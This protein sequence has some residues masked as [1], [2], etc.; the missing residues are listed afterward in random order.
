M[1][2]NRFAFFIQDL[3]GGGAERAV[4]RLANGIAARNIPTDLVLVARRGPFLAEVGAAVEIVELPQSRTVTSVLG[5]ADYVAKRR[6]AALVSHMT[7]TNVAAIAATALTRQRPRL[8]VVEHNRFDVAQ[9]RRRGLPRLAY[10]L[11]PLVYRYADVVAVVADGMRGRIAEAARIPLEKV[12]VLRNPVISPELLAQAKEEPP[13]PWFKPGEVPVILAVGRLTR[14]KNF[15]M[16]LE[17][18]AKL[19]GR[20]AA[21]LVILGEGEERV[22]LEGLIAERRLQADVDLPGFAS[23][24]FAYMA[25]AGVFALSSDWE[26]LPTVLIE[27]LACGVPLVATDCES[28]PA[29]ILDGGRYGRLVATGDANAFADALEA[30]LDDPGERS[31]SARIARAMDFA[32]ERAIDRYLDVAGFG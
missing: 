24:P 9:A 20:R 22:A 26:G 5:L 3:R 27:A 8:I 2:S 31:R 18:F 21:R 6:P 17:A 7:H 29:E 32:F 16:L 1:G 25:H 12:A 13:H 14:Q 4:V 23:N 15:A 11:V 30:A 10:N 19:R 28:G